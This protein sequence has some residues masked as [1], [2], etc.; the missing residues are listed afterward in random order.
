MIKHCLKMILTLVLSTLVLVACKK[1]KDQ[2]PDDTD[3]NLIIGTWKAVSGAED[4]NGNHQRDADENITLPPEVIITLTLNKDG[5]GSTYEYDSDG[6][7]DKET[8]TWESR[9]N[10]QIL[11]LKYSPSEEALIKIV[12]LTQTDL[13]LEVNDDPEI[14]WYDYKRQ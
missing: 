13:T 5:T 14:I 4:N 2:T 9:N 11:V 7:E 1:D 8:F 3:N 12:T 6:T 10:N